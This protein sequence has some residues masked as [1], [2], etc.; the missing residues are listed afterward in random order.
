L[1]SLEDENEDTV[2]LEILE[3]SKDQGD[4]KAQ[5]ASA[6]DWSSPP[7]VCPNQYDEPDLVQENKKMNEMVKRKEKFMADHPWNK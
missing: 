2:A 6:K 4:Q 7:P 5:L 1:E 3:S